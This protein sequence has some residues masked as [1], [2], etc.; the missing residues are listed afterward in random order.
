MINNIFEAWGEF[1]GDTK[2]KQ[3]LKFAICSIFQQL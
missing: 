1:K 3:L 2:Y